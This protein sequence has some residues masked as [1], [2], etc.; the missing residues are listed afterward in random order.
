MA[1]DSDP[2]ADFFGPGSD[3]FL[4]TVSLKGAPLDPQQLGPAETIITFKIWIVDGLQ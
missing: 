3:P 2:P 1:Y 4:G